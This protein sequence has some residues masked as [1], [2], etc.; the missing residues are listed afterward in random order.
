MY[1]QIAALVGYRNAL[2]GEFV[3][4]PAASMLDHDTFFRVYYNCTL[5]T[6]QSSHPLCFAVSP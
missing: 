4:W 5:P 6:C 3:A 2:Y 1:I